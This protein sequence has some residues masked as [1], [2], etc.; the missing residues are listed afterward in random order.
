[1][2]RRPWRS[3][4]GESAIAGL[5]VSW[6]LD[7]PEMLASVIVFGLEGGLRWSNVFFEGCRGQD[8]QLAFVW[9]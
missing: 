7:V 4:G 1:M 9:P 6:I 2:R 8:G 3:C 5:R